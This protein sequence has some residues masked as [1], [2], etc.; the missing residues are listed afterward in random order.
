MKKILLLTLAAASVSAYGQGLRIGSYYHKQQRQK[1]E[2]RRNI[3]DKGSDT[4]TEQ[5]G[6]KEVCCATC[7]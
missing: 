6:K 7:I 5:N 4:T 1:A 2:L 3:T